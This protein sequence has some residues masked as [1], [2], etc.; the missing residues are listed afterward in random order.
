MTDPERR[1]RPIPAYRGTMPRA[2]TTPMAARSGGRSRAAVA[3]LLLATAGL[4]LSGCGGNDSAAPVKRTSGD[5]PTSTTETT[6]AGGTDSGGIASGILSSSR[7]SKLDPNSVS[8]D[9]AQCLGSYV[10]DRVGEQEAQTISDEAIDA[11]TPDQLAVLT[12]GFNKCISGA[13][14]AGDL[15]TSFYEG[16]GVRSTPTDEVVACVADGI[17]GRT[18]DVVAESATLAES[19]TAP[20][21]LSVMDTCV[22]ASEVTELLRSAFQEAGLTPA[23][24]T[25]TAGALEGKIS[26]SELAEIGSAS[27]LPPEIEAKVTTAAQG[28]KGAG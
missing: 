1:F 28:C 8:D 24:A 13:T 11:L 3:V 21:T 19:A 12:A 23:Q 17:D 14:M 16:A 7:A 22:P 10:I 4:V 18:G 25:C 6:T 26:L 9:E 15:V 2:T 5:R 20:I 27:S